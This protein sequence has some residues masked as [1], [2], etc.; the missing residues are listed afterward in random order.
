MV[1]G[2]APVQAGLRRA[3][4]SGALAGGGEGLRLPAAAGR[5]A[6]AKGGQAVDRRQLRAG[7]RADDGE[8]KESQNIVAWAGDNPHE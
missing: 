2:R 8:V 5:D 1:S 4:G 7:A 6:R 3:E